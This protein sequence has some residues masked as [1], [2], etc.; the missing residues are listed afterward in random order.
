MP[1]SIVAR[2]REAWG[3]FVAYRP[4]IRELVARDLKV[5]YRRSFLGYLWSIL[6]PLLMMVIQTI[7][8]SYMF[9]TNIDNFP[10]YLIC[11]NVLYS[12]FSDSTTI[13]MDCIVNNAS[14]IKKVYIPKF[15]FPISIVT[16]RFVMLMLSL[17]ATVIV[18]LATGAPFRPIAL[19]FWVPL[20]ILYVFCCG[21]S[22]MLSAFTVFFRDLQH[23]YGVLTM[24]LMYMTPIFYPMQSID[25]V[26][27]NY[28]RYNPL[29]SY[30]EMFRS[31]VM[32]GKNPDQ[33]IW[34][35][36]ICWALGTLLIGMTVFR[37]LQKKFILYI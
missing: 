33:F 21:V 15:I 10:L 5:K 13:G 6:N 14:L 2:N 20:A 35:N 30:I 25:P 22:L 1:K 32:Y 12:F 31:F 17:L 27:Q 19:L 29:Y 37:K 3:H 9:R 26:L 7:V 36:C 23:I 24:G 28:V 18:M 16:S 11:G 34:T 4:L 8:F